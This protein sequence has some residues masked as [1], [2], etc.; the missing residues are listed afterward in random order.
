M[1]SSLNTATVTML[2]NRSALE[3][4]DMK[5]L[6]SRLFK[7]FPF[8]L[9]K[10]GKEPL[11]P[12]LIYHGGY[13]P[14]S[15]YLM[16]YSGPRVH[17]RTGNPA[18]LYYCF[19]PGRNQVPW[20]NSLWLGHGISIGLGNFTSFGFRTFNWGRFWQGFGPF[21]GIL[22]PGKNTRQP[23]KATGWLHQETKVGFPSC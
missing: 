18:Q 3:R 6:S 12:N 17:F 8:I 13:S 20:R 14:Y 21:K 7:T 2:Q 9:Q 15:R 5:N 23:G 19:K 22:G 1:P 4:N 11:W 16:V 10:L